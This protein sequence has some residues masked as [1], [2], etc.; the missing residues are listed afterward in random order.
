MGYL[1]VSSCCAFIALGSFLF[2]YDAGVIAST[3]VQADFTARF[4]GA[5]SD[6][7]IGGI[8]SSYTGKHF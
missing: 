6:T 7:T 8:V 4:K 2:G 1:L 3:I 5:L